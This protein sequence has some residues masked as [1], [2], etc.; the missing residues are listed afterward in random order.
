MTH[1]GEGAV[2]FIMAGMGLMPAAEEAVPHIA[3]LVLLF[4]VFCFTEQGTVL[5]CSVLILRI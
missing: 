3:G 2:I 4:L 5:K 1:P